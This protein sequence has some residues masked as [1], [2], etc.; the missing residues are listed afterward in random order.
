MEINV[1]QLLKSPVGTTR[2]Y[3][4]DPDTRLTLDADLVA[5]I[6]EGHVRLDRTNTAIL[7]RGQVD[8]V[9][10]MTCARCLDAVEVEEEISFAEQYEPS[11]DVTTGRPL[12]ASEDEES[13]QISPNHLLDIGE[14][15]RQNL[16]A[17]LPIAPL[18]QPECAG[19][20]PTCG[21]NR[22]TNPCQCAQEEPL[23]EGYTRPFAALADLL[24]KAQ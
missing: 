17:A 7:A 20:C 9:V 6:I 13:F 18:C 2:E 22:N 21:A 15:V 16:V 23:P 19:L 14:A 8:A 5:T 4:F 12:P 3:D 24:D 1:A 10:K 11:V